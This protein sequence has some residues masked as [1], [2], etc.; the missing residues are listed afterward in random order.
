[1]PEV[2][3]S[4]EMCIGTGGR[5]YLPMPEVAESEKIRIGTGEIFYT[6]MPRETKS[7]AERTL[8]H[9]ISSFFSVSMPLVEV[10]PVSR[11]GNF[12][13]SLLWYGDTY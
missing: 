7:D 12:Y 4:V 5:S 11:H 2:A 9:Q 10:Q 3:E 13:F 6:P 1:M 8:G